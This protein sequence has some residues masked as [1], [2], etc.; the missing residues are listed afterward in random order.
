MRT[1]GAYS[2]LENVKYRYAFLAQIILIKKGEINFPSKI[3]A[4]NEK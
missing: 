2:Y 4:I 3:L 1:A